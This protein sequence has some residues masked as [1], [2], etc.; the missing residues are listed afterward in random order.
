MM[1]PFAD[2]FDDLFMLRADMQ[3]SFKLLGI[4]Q[5]EMENTRDAILKENGGTTTERLDRYAGFSYEF[6]RL[7]PILNVFQARMKEHVD[8]LERIENVLN[9]AASGNAEKTV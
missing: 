9:A 7:A 2:V 4:Y 6:D 8:T 1:A 3:D 5:N